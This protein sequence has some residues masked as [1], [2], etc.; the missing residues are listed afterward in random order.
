M[1][2]R[3]I[4]I[5]GATSGIGRATA[6]ACARVGARVV[7]C[8]RRVDVGEALV[9]EVTSQGGQAIFVPTD[10][11]RE[12]D[13]AAAVRR[14]VE[15]FGSLDFAFNN[16]GI[17]R[18]EP[19]LADYQD[20]LWH[21]HV[22]VGLTGVYYCMRHELK[23]MLDQ[24]GEHFAIINNAST[25]G[26]RGSAASGAGYTAVKH[27]IIGLTRQAAVEYAHTPVRIN[28]V[29]PGPTLTEATAPALAR[30]GADEEARSAFLGSLNPT[31]QLVDVDDIAQTVVFLCSQAGS[32]INGHALP[33][34]GGQ[35]A[36]L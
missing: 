34:D 10:V 2:G 12:G 21:E 28:A 8:G 9:D 4:L 25:V 31:A 30:F 14:A 11:T 29:C 20:D 5:T 17:F 33:L 15:H 1:Q 36:S 3:T 26:S 23:V 32:M 22:A 19:A 35:L 27:G 18:A 7:A 13:V 6:V 24:A 16:A